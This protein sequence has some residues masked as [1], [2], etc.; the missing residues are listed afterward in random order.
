MIASTIE[1]ECF[2]LYIEKCIWSTI[3]EEDEISNPILISFSLF[4]L[5]L[6]VTLLDIFSYFFFLRICDIELIRF[7]FCL[8]SKIIDSFTI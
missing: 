5:S 1:C 7:N 3:N 4:F 2:V 6:S 8:F